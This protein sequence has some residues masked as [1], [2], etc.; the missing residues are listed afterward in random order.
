MG[1]GTREGREKGEI[2]KGKERGWD[3]EEREEEMSPR[4]HL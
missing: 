4:A 1:Q 2:R 3:V